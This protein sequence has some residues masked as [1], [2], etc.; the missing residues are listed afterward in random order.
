[1]RLVWDLPA[2]GLAPRVYEIEH[3]LVEY[4]GPQLVTLR[5]P[6][7]LYIGVASDEENT[8]VRWIYAPISRT[9]FRALTD[10][11]CSL[12]DCLLKSE[13]AIVDVN[14]D[15]YAMRE[16]LADSSILIDDALP[17]RGALLPK[18]VRAEFA[19]VAPE[20][21]ELRLDA[22]SAKKVGFRPLAEVLS[23]YQRLWHAIA[24][25]RTSRRSIRGRWN[26]D[27]STRTELAVVGASAG[28][29]VLNIEPTDPAI[30][31]EIA[32]T[33]ERLAFVADDVSALA[34]QLSLLGPRVQGRYGELLSNLQKNDLQILSR[35]AGGSAFLSSHTATRILAAMPQSVAEKPKTV[36]LSG[37]FVAFNTRSQTFEFYEVGEEESYSGVVHPEVL[38][39]NNSVQVGPGTS[40]NVRIEVIT[41]VLAHEVAQTYTLRQIEGRT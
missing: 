36:A 37:F 35:R 17:K 4:E 6:D 33:F 41:Y 12:R 31:G 23:S 7:G 11:A 3:I 25:A 15:G 22:R 14:H 30:Y 39:Q 2:Q 5:G 29:L 40:Y 9:E 21:P 28:S 10:G 34:D 16:W 27:L 1:M 8:F 24:Q 32:Q 38:A 18:A 26:Q 13:I 19:E 20:R